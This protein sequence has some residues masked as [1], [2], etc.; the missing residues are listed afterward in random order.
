MSVF[1]VYNIGTGHAS[2]EQANLLVRLFNRTVGIDARQDR[3]GR[4]AQYR[5]INDGIGKSYDART[6]RVSTNMFAQATGWG[7]KDKTEETVDVIRR[8]NPRVVNLVG[9][10]RG[11]IIAVRTA[12]KL[13]KRAPDI[14]CNLFLV[15]PVKRSFLGKDEDNAATHGNVRLFRQILM[16]SE[17]SWLFEPQKMSHS[18]AATNSVRL[19]GSHGSA[20]QT[21]QPIGVVAYMLAVNF[22]RLCGT[23]LSDTP[24]S[25]VQ[26]ADAYAQI[27]LMNPVHRRNGVVGREVANWDGQREKKFRGATDRRLDSRFG[28]ENPYLHHAYFVNNDHARAFMQ[29]FP[30]TFLA[31]TGKVRVDRLM[32]RALQ[33]ELQQMRA[34]AARAFQTL[35][36]AYREFAG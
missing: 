15:D 26:M 31:L 8:I 33:R 9:H 28:A 3:P 23:A 32:G 1:T 14:T 24:F 22:L 10:S 25:P 7:L 36:T 13:S 11:A 17:S 21:G 20:T 4:A 19:P 5:Y 16:E 34:Q 2:N 18:S 6:G 30:N 12:A 29:S 27:T 35:P